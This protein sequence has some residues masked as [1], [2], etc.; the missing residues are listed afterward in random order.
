M[1]LQRSVNNVNIALSGNSF[2]SPFY[3]NNIQQQFPPL[4]VYI[5]C[6]YQSIN[7]YY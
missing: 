1:Q 4:V 7:F 5:Y 2:S 3:I 6:I